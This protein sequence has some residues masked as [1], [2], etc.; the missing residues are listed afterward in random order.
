MS[1][2]ELLMYNE[3]YEIDHEVQKKRGLIQGWYRGYY[4]D[5]D[6]EMEDKCFN[7][8]SVKMIW[9]VK[10]LTSKFDIKEFTRFQGLLFQLYFMFDH[11]CTI[12]VMLHDL[13]NFCFDHDCSGEMLL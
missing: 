13:S 10:D 9:H 8:D 11:E 12:D 1:E 5:Y 3:M 2:E 7:K 6:W 4:K